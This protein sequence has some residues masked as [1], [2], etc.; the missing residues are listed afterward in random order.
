[1]FG[2]NLIIKSQ[3]FIFLDY[4]IKRME[5]ITSVYFIISIHLQCTIIHYFLKQVESDKKV[6]TIILLQ[7]SKKCS[8]LFKVKYFMGYNLQTNHFFNNYFLKNIYSL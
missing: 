6:T 5:D 7:I 4:F 1:M 2:S 3:I 8:I